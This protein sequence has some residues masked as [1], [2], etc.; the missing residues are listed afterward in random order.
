MLGSWQKGFQR[1]WLKGE[2]RQPST[3][4]VKEECKESIRSEQAD[5]LHDQASVSS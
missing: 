4:I 3:Y 1:G 2:P 5:L